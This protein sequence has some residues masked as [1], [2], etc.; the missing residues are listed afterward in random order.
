[1]IHNESTPDPSSGLVWLGC[2]QSESVSQPLDDLTQR[3][4]CFVSDLNATPRDGFDQ[5]RA[6][7][8]EDTVLTLNTEVALWPPMALWSIDVYVN[9]YGLFMSFPK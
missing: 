8:L 4:P 6:M 1:M 7:P 5:T 2:F 3:I 9:V